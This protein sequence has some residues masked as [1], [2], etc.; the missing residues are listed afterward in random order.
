M[1]TKLEDGY[2]LLLTVPASSA[3]EIKKRELVLVS[4]LDRENSSN[5]QILVGN[6]RY[7]FPVSYL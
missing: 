5:Y 2:R 1:I 4:P 7:E 3:F 6:E